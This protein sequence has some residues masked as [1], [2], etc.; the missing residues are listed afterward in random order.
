MRNILL[1]AA[2]LTAGLAT[3]ATPIDGWYTSA[4]GGYTYV[5]DNLNTYRYG[6]YINHGSFNKGYNVGG[7]IGFKS[8]P[9]RYEAEYTF[10]HANARNFQLNYALQSGVTGYSSANLLMAN[11]YYDTPEMLPAISPFLGLGLGYAYVQNGLN[12]TGPVVPLYFSASRNSFA[13]QGTVGLTYDFA[14]NYAINLAYRYVA[15]TSSDNFGSIFQAHIA[16]AG[17]VYRF[18]NGL[19][20]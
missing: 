9:M 7:R 5:P 13:Y 11:V 2:L 19:Y 14:E 10:I 15:T 1:S 18:D 8:N 20:K 4:F 3:A 16:N 12:S 17:V 6:Y